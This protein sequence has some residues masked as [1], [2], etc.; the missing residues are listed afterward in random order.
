MVRAAHALDDFFGLRFW[1]AALLRHDFGQHGVDFARHICGVT[2]DV[3]VRF[4]EEE[5]VNF[6]GVFEE[7]VLHVDFA[8]AFAGEGGYE[9][10]FIAKSFL[11]LLLISCQ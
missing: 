10:E 3:E 5:L 7:T 4:L 8:G 11:V 9:G 6:F 2:A 1:D